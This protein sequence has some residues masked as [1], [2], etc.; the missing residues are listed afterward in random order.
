MTSAL[1]HI[2]E[3]VM[4]HE[5]PSCSCK[6]SSAIRMPERLGPGRGT[7]SLHRIFLL[8]SHTLARMHV[9]PGTH[10]NL[11]ELN[12]FRSA[13]HVFNRKSVILV[14]LQNNTM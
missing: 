11:I 4:M 10:L 3:D 5:G 9:K 8:S 13:H 14:C 6:E 1:L 12:R 2:C 7:G